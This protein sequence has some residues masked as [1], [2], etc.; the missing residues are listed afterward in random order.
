M[1]TEAAN[2]DVTQ[3]RARIVTTGIGSNGK[4]R[5][6]S[7]ELG[8]VR[9]IAPVVTSTILWETTS[10][11]V[12]VGVD[13]GPSQDRYIPVEGGLRVFHVSFAPDNMV[14]A[15]ARHELN[16]VTGL[17][18]TS[19]DRAVGFHTTPTVDV[20]TVVTGEL[21]CLLDEGEVLLRAGDTL[22]QRATTHSW[23]NRTDQIVLAVAVMVSARDADGRKV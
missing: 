1:E 19:E 23:S 16:D 2:L 13:E 7:D 5:V 4:S 21:Y 12:I 11:P 20:L 10:V 15:A 3:Q 22:V 14:D 6:V 8:A 9:F 18:Q 17:E